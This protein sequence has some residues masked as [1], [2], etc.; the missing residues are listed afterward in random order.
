[1]ALPT[2]HGTKEPERPCSSNEIPYAGVVARDKLA[3]DVYQSVLRTRRCD[4]IELMNCAPMASQYHL[5]AYSVLKFGVSGAPYAYLPLTLQQPR[6]AET[7]L[8]RQRK[9]ETHAWRVKLHLNAG[10]GLKD[11]SNAIHLVDKLT[12]GT[13]ERIYQ[14]LQVA[15]ADKSQAESQD[16]AC[17]IKTSNSHPISLSPIIPVHLLPYIS[18]DVLSH[19]PPCFKMPETHD[20]SQDPVHISLKT[21][22]RREDLDV[23]L[24]KSLQDTEGYALGQIR[25]EHLVRMPRS[26]PLDSSCPGKKVR[27]DEPFQGR[28]PICRDLKIDLDRI[29]QMGVRAIVC[30]LDDEELNM[31]GAPCHEYQEQAQSQGFDLICLPMAEG[32]APINMTRLDMIMSMLILNYTL[33]GTSILV[34]CR[35]G[36]G[37]AGLVACIWLLKM[38]LVSLGS[39]D[40]PKLCPCSNTSSQVLDTVLKLIDTVRKRRSLRA[41]ET[42][43][44]AR[45]LMEY[46]RFIFGQERARFCL[47]TAM[48]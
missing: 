21:T 41:I 8:E 44:Q 16:S 13:N 10:L 45:F 46:V 4:W 20:K 29:R 3:H 39:E 27:L 7:V 22:V 11:T 23:Y 32:F 31:L 30:C 14:D 1:M 25:G 17:V 35:G 26:V 37:R 24:E 15:M 47:K 34:H 33:R 6:L 12:D 40:T 19:L 42:A 36:V 43:E 28:S 5:S 2:P 9:N 48:P 18:A 38:N